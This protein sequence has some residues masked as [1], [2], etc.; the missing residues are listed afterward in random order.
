P[1]LSLIKSDGNISAVPGDTVVYTLGYQNTGN[2][3]LA[4]VLLTE[5]VPANTTFNAA[6]SSADWDCT[7]GDPA[8][9][10]CTLLVGGLAGG[11]TGS[12]TFA[13]TILNAVPA[14][15]TQI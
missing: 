5:Q 3:G 7:N 14:G 13:V 1:G 9:S 2:V 12:D 8:G 4:G 10:I 15:T 6:G 11:A